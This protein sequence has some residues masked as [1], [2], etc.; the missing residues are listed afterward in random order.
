MHTPDEVAESM[1]DSLQ[2]PDGSAAL[3]FPWSGYPVR[4]RRLRL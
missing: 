1:S 2:S 4:L 3:W